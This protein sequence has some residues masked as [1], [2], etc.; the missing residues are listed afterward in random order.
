MFGELF[1]EGMREEFVGGLE[2]GVRSEG[3]G[4]E[5]EYV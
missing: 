4:E 1:A 3:E 2:L 5:E